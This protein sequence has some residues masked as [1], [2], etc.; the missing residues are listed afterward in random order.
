M[1]SNLTCISGSP[2]T[3]NT[4]AM[5]VNP[6]LPVSVSI[7]VNQNNICAGTSVTFTAS[8][9]NGGTP[10][11]QWYKNTL[12]VGF[13]QPTYICTPVNGDQVYVVMS[14]GLACISG[15]PAT[16]N[17]ITMIVNP[18]L[19]VSVSIGV[20]QNNICAGTSVTFTATP[21]N[22][23][24]PVYQWY[25]NT[26]PVGLNQPTFTCTPVNGDQVYVV[27]SSGL[28][29]ISG[30]PA[31]SNTI[32]MIVNPIL[33]V[34]VSIGVNQNNICA[35]TSVTFTAT[36]VNGGT[37]VYQWY[38][39]T[40]PVGLNQ[41][42]YTCT[43][44]NG[45]QVYVVMSSNLTCI[46][47]S[48]AT[49]NTI[50]MIVNPILPVSVSIGVN[51]NNIC[52][53][54]SVT[55]TATPVN[56]GTPVYQWYKNTLPVSLNQP[57]YTY[58]PVNGD[59]VYVVMSSGLSCISGS[60]ATSN[61]IT[62]IVNPIL[63]VSVSIGVNQNNICTGTSVTFTATP[64]NGGTP[65]YQ[66]YKNTLPVGLNQ[67]TYTCTPVNGDQ[68]YVVM[69]SGLSCISGSPAT[70][71]TIAMI[72]NP[73]LPV[74]VSIGVNQNN[75][76]AGTPV[77]FTATP[78]NGGTP[79]YQWY[80]NTLPVGLNQPTY[81][82]TPVNGDQVYV[83]MSSNLVCISGSPA[84]SNTIAMIVNPILP[85]S[86][87]IGVDQ[88][89]ICAGTSVTFTA[90]PVNGGTPVYQW[91]K[92]TFPVGFNQPTYTC[93]PVNG[94]QVYVVISSSLTCISGS[95]ATS[96]TITMVVNPI[97]LVNVTI[98]VDQ[99]EVCEGT[100]VFF[101]A[102]P[103]NG[104]TP[105]YQWYK[106][107]LP[108]GSNLPTYTYIPV[109]S[110]QVY[111]IMTSSETCTSGNPAMSNVITITVDTPLP[112]DVSISVDQNNVCEGTSVTFTA[113]PTNEGTPT[114]QWF[115]DGYPVGGNQPTFTCV[116]ANN[117]QIYVIMISSLT[118][119]TNNP[120][121]SNTI[122]MFVNLLPG[123]AGTISGP[124]DVCDGESGVSYSVAPIPDAASY[125]W[126]LPPGATIVSGNNTPNITVDFS[127]GA[128]SGSITVLGS[129]AC[130]NGTL[131]P[132]FNVTVNPIPLTP[133]VTATGQ[134]LQS[135]APAGN[136]WY[137]N[138]VIIPGAT[139]QNYFATQPGW[140]WTVVTLNTC[141]SDTSNH[142]YVAGVGIEEKP[143]GANFLVYPVPNNGCF[144][145]SIKLPSE[146]T[147]NI[148]IYNN[149]GVQIYQLRD[150]KVREKFEKVIDLRPLPNGKYLIV[151]SGLERM[152]VSKILVQK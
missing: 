132:D 100:P 12:P 10:V 61:T 3:S 77:T 152:V 31:T 37:A 36:P 27:I 96:N 66:W 13:N 44:V 139:G 16:S 82:Y 43:P 70:S 54:T 93:A 95:P 60:P 75:I 110:D 15:S 20:N 62:I 88:N 120:A 71:N 55:F 11:Y 138:G 14:S 35:G 130:G 113:I 78:V 135:S 58:T 149:L 97:L 105:S 142:V 126:T 119:V 50:T 64:V 150:V 125:V 90:T 28:A 98:S 146:D 148:I 34:S 103:I 56:G 81:T 115:Q 69:S 33:P 1:S 99:D 32:A 85:V 68:V 30:S 42:T 94:D 116:P 9:V 53:G 104:G 4:I 136:Q 143:D 72:V 21:V 19:P 128:N 22:G 144:T 39:N 106:N 145:V 18:I 63:P 2:A 91:Y 117:D 140:Y 65:V 112:V 59:Q 49:S 129:N 151:F 74:S 118:C 17:T 40:L 134:D 6:I 101:T 127:Q 41:P 79:V 102:N 89:N 67:P 25:K 45:D 29:C 47:G 133:V 122:T 7:G 84:T 24:T 124:S 48:P 137:Y 52:A 141:S 108:V 5:I 111:V 57:T 73:I 46:S 147:Y 26:L 107:T 38:K 123:A 51:Q 92:N 131:S 76:C 86:V 80:K 83:V 121:T 109:N 8:P 23:G 87:S 114:Y